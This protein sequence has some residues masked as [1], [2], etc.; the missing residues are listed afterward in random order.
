[1]NAK[2]LFSVVIAL[3]VIVLAPGCAYRPT[4]EPEDTTDRDRVMK[5]V[6]RATKLLAEENRK[7][8]E[9]LQGRK[10]SLKMAPLPPPDSGTRKSLTFQWVGPAESALREL[11]KKAGYRFTVSSR[12][13]PAQPLIVVVDERKTAIYLIIDNINWQLDSGA[14]VLDHISKTVHLQYLVARRESP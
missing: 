3:V 11:A 10:R 8:R 12:P 6:A 5:E 14:V 1:M 7:L 13:L 4:P 2:S 9:L